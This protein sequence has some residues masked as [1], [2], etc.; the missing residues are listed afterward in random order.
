[1][2]DS[3]YKIFG[4]N[5]GV[6]ILCILTTFISLYEKWKSI[7]N[8]NYKDDIEKQMLRVRESNLAMQQSNL[9]LRQRIDRYLS[10]EIITVEIKKLIS[11]YENL[12]KDGFFVE[13][14]RLFYRE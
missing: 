11:I 2:I 9:N 10:P 7:Q 8:S 4:D 3:V 5:S 12:S 14:K 6:K 1:M 13:V